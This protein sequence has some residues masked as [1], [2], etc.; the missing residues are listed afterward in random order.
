[1][2]YHRTKKIPNYSPKH[3]YTK[4]HDWFAWRP[5]IISDVSDPNRE[6]IVWLRTINR[7]GVWESYRSGS[8]WQWSYEF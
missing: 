3:P 8:T 1:M 7:K 2:I 4:W 5:I 6:Y